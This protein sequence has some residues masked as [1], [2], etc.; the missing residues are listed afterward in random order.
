MDYKDG[1]PADTRL[2]RRQFSTAFSAAVASAACATGGAA[3]T[4][5]DGPSDVALPWASA[6][7]YS[8][9]VARAIGYLESQGQAPDGSFAAQAGVGVTALATAAILRQG[10]SIR[11]PLVAKALKYLETFV[12]PDGGVYSPGGMLANYET[13]LAIMCLTEANAD[14]RYHR[15]LQR[16]EAYVRTHQWDES[17][18]KEPD[19]VAYGGAGY[20]KHKRPDLSNT[21]FLIDAL[22][23][24]GRGPNDPDTCGPDDPAI[25]KALV[26][27]SRCQNLESAHNT[28]P[29]A[30]KI[31]NG[32]FYYT[33]AAGGRSPA[34]LTANGGLRSYAS[35][36]YSGLKSMLHAGLGP[37]DPR[38]KAAVAWI[39][40]HYDLKSNPGLGDAGLYYYYH[41]FAKTL[42]V[43]GG[44]VFEDAVGVKHDWR[45]EL[46]AELSASQRENGSWVNANNRW[47]EGDPNL[48]TAY[49]LLA[50][51]YCRPQTP[52]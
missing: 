31:N 17:Q 15:I 40:N 6:D 43:L 4:L 42:H 23:A 10:R 51:S 30:A 50:I 1:K 21:T 28:T 45:C 34:G 7:Q 44:A 3:A 49:S 52:S 37:D 13:C 35:M 8:R 26:F 20:G 12:Q 14:R 48:A 24:C 41:T 39:R 5:A 2:S 22:K 33:C 29:F 32:G 36:T 18:R 27:V 25:Q 16:A 38:V 19:D 46:A 47:M 11:D 9:C